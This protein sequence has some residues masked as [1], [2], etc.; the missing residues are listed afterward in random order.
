MRT[1]IT[2]TVHGAKWLIA[3]AI[4]QLPEV[5]EALKNGK[6]ILK[7]GTTVSCIAEEMIG[8]KLRISGRI[9][10]KGTM[11]SFEN[12]DSPHSVLIENGGW[13]KIDDNFLD[14][15]L[16][17]SPK[18]III[19]GANMI[20]IEGNAAMMA[21]SPGGGNPGKAIAALTT[22]GANVIIA[23]GLE[24]LI[25]GKISEIIGKVGRKNCDYAMGMAVGLMPIFGRVI[26]E[27]DALKIITDA[28][29][30]IIGRGGI[31]GGEGSTTVL[32][33]GNEESLQKAIHEVIAANS[34][35]V[36]GDKKSLKE[37]RPKS[38]GCAYHLSCFYSHKSKI[39]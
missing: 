27:I 15:V 37:C 7:G 12:T 18:N 3:R 5:K 23:A 38:P 36:S 22:E 28:N 4:I 8:I 30:I 35:P 17:M 29:V 9:T 11:T 20:D 16:K 26:T 6:I 24:K 39:K 21:G 14:A 2:I 10:K 25:P 19:I 13:Q 34:R 33:E 32:L 31:D 1:Q